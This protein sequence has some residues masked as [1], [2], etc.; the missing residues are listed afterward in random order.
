MTRVEQYGVPGRVEDPVDRQ[1]EFDDTEIWAQV[2]TGLRH[3]LDEEVPD[4]TGEI[5]QL[6]V[7]KAA[8]VVW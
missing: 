4:L 8:Q 3:L 6:T 2:T 5:V 1:G 7:I